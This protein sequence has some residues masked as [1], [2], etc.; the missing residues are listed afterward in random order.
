VREREEASP[1]FEA[2]GGRCLAIGRRIYQLFPE[3]EGGVPEDSAV[4]GVAAA[5]D[6]D[7]TE[8]ARRRRVRR[9]G[10]AHGP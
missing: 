5:E 2:A 7:P 8:L 6:A 9:G 4:A 3:V 1:S 10:V